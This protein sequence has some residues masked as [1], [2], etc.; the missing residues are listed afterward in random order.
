MQAFLKSVDPEKFKS[1]QEDYDAMAYHTEHELSNMLAQK[2]P[3]ITQLR[4]GKKM[5]DR[6]CRENDKFRY[7]M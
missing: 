7:R 3:S 6:I 5:M 4:E 1:I 2:K